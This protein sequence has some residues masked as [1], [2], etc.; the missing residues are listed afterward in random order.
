MG[1]PSVSAVKNMP[2]KQ[3]T[4]VQSLSKEDPLE[5]DMP[6]HS[7]SLPWEIPWAEESRGLQSTG[8]QRI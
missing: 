1:F 4:W 5:K 7:T 6:T 8:L 3:Q 2:A